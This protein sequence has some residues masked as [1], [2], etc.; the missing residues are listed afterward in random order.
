MSTYWC[1]II[2]RNRI[3]VI[4][5]LVTKINNFLGLQNVQ[6]Y[7]GNNMQRLLHLNHIF[8]RMNG[9][10]HHTHASMHACTHTRIHNSLLA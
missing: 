10:H 1:V 9:Y 5:I 2:S 4:A 8:Q 3:F 7:Y 6:L